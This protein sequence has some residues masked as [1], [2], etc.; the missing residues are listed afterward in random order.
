MWTLCN[1]VQPLQHTTTHR[2]ALQHAATRCNTLQHAA[3]HCNTLQYTAIHSVQINSYLQRRQVVGVPTAKIKSQK[4]SSL[5]N[6]IFKP[7]VALTLQEFC[8]QDSCRGGRQYEYRLTRF[9]NSQQYSD[10]HSE[11]SSELTFEKFYRPSGRIPRTA[12]TDTVVCDSETEFVAPIEHI[13]FSK[14]VSDT[15]FVAPVEQK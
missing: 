11:F 14:S 6:S 12:A 7:T 13:P 9:L 1:T 3:I 5:S 15:E 2:N 4:V 10:S 8:R